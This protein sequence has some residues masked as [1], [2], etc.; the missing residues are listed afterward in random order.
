[1]S[2]KIIQY[3]FIVALLLSTIS[4]KAT[5]IVIENAQ[6]EY[7]IS[8]KG[9]NLR[10][11]YKPYKKDYLYKDSISYCAYI[12]INKKRYHSTEAVYK[13]Q[14]LAI[15]FD[16]AG[17]SV[18]LDITPRESHFLWQ[19]KEVS[20]KV[21]AL[22]FL[23][24]PLIVQGLPEE[25]FAACALSMNLQTKVEQLPALQTWLKADAYPFP[26][27]KGAAVAL[28][29]TSQENI[30]PLIRTVMPEA[31][32][33]VSKAGGAWAKLSADSYGSYLMNF[34]NLTEANVDQWIEYCNSV[35]FN[36]IDHHGGEKDFFRFGDFEL[37]PEK[38][39]EGW[40][41]FRRINQRLHAAGISSIFHTYAFFLEKTSRYV[42]PVPS[43]DL[44][45]FST[46]TLTKPVGPSDTIIEVR[47]ST[48]NL[49]VFTGFHVRNSVTVR[50]GDE[51][52][53]FSDRTT[54]PP[55]R[56]TGC[57]RGA[58]GTKAAAHAASDSVYH[59]KEL[60][61]RFLPGP[62]TILFEE[63][64]ARTAEIVNKYGFDAIYFDAI[65]GSD[66]L[67]GHQTSWYHASRFLSIV[68]EKLE[69]PVG[70]EMSAM[71]HHFWHYR[72]R[73]QA[74][75]VSRRG[76]KRFVDIHAAAINK[77]LLLPLNLGWW[78]NFTWEPPQTEFTFPDDVEYLGCKMIG[79]DAGL[80]LLGGYEK[81]DVAQNPSFA[82]LN[83]I[84]KQYEELRHSGTVSG[85]IKKQLSVP[86]KEFTLTRNPKGKLFFK[87][88]AYQKHRIVNGD[89]SLDQWEVHNEFHTQ[90]LRLR[91]QPLMGVGSFNDPAAQTL[92]AYSEE[93]ALVNYQ[94]APEINTA[95]QIKEV[96]E[97]EAPGVK[98]A[99]VFNISNN[100]NTP[101]NGSWTKVE[102]QFTPWKDIQ[103]NQALGV[104]VKGD[105][106][107]QLLNLRLESPYHLG[108][109][110]RGDHFITIDF[111]G[112]KYF[113]LL[114]I[115]SS[116]YSDYKWPAGEQWNIYASHM[117]SIQYNAIDKL[118]FW[119]NNIPPG[120]KVQT[121]IGPVK[122]LPMLNWSLE[123]PSIELDGKKIVFP[124][125]LQSGMYLEF[126]SMQDCKLYDSKGAFVKNIMPVGD[127]PV[128]QKGKNILHFSCDTPENLNPRVEI[129]V[130]STGKFLKNK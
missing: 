123:N 95:F 50:I 127:T 2:F 30:L 126:N 80:S 77:G 52:I 37:N 15:R 48:A 97:N 67:D 108:T 110:A 38:W 49:S 59:L 90:P 101:A 14:E 78:L 96:T 84:I 81:K 103:H 60:F 89:A 99:G 109:G 42:S 128:L 64:A 106:G 34:G 107:G 94:T 129:T 41:H 85:H 3:G 124:V 69:R 116:A 63:V 32:F 39:P 82:R 55:Y 121:I 92:V 35:G 16:S 21:D 98:R 111:T 46:F 26:G 76:H 13:D 56:L 6:L 122:A 40:E 5:D 115:E 9:Q 47:E 102:K 66:I 7:V 75:D 31:A 24:I 74:W 33:P 18:T 1:M 57:K 100:G 71:F 4:G 12:K 28:L 83:Q 117:F 125:T 105:G 87:P 86:G 68:A 118:Q 53:E 120:K 54:S 104:W 8:P 19:L 72:S 20:G 45:Y 10:F 88:A 17:I 22:T 79:F 130:M 65:D 119:F 11:V 51:L 25:A 36:Q 113:E 29:T 93:D 112:W 23:N 91:I 73:W 58:N 114:E 43:K 62:N 44:D 27:F 61:G 70:M